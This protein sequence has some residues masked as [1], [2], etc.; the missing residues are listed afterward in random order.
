[1]LEAL[2]PRVALATCSE[3]PGLDADAQLLASALG[4]RRIEARATVWDDPTIDWEAFDLVVIRSCWDYAHRRDEFL[5]WTRQVPRLANPS[6]AIGWNTDKR[7]LQELDLLGVP[8]VPTT[9]VEPG[10]RWTADGDGE[11]VVKPSVSLA[12]LDTGRYRLPRER[13]LAVE[14]VQRL[15]RQGRTVM[16][17]PY[18]S[19]IDEQGETSLVYLGG[20]LSHAIRKP[21]L[22]DGP[23]TG[24]DRRFAHDGGMAPGRC[25]PTRAQV[26]LAERVLDVARTRADALL[27]ARADLLPSSHG[28]VLLE[29]ELTEPQ[30]FFRH[31]PGSAERLAGAIADRISA[32]ACRA[33]TR[34]GGRR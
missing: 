34:S 6:A 3:L 30:L 10:Q 18:Q 11:W 15:G 20:V 19:A 28:P 32:S 12:A 13:A 1:V 24:I 21:A 29:L 4:E 22:L 27:Y 7:Y 26:A 25:T 33:P 9:W 23:D 31:A 14:H 8:V 16:L 5:A 17:Q 2:R